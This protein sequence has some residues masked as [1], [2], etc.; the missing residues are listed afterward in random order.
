MPKNPTLFTPPSI[1]EYEITQQ[2]IDRAYAAEAGR[3]KRFNHS[4]SAIKIE[5]LELKEN[6]PIL[7]ECCCPNSLALH[8]KLC[9]LIP[10]NSGYTFGNVTTDGEIVYFDCN[11]FT[12]VYNEDRFVDRIVWGYDGSLFWHEGPIKLD[13]TDHITKPRP[14]SCKIKFKESVVIK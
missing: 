13:G 10:E 7:R 2:H 5:F 14:V 3:F 1:I 9:E 12:H 11:G 6:I 4:K 8:D